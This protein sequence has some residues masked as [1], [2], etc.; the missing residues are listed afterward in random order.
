LIQVS[1]CTCRVWRP[2]VALAP[3]AAQRRDTSDVTRDDHQELRLR[4]RVELVARPL[5]IS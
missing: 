4:V 2:D 3:R 1:A 5:S